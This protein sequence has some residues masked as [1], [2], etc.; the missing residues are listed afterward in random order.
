MVLEYALRSSFK[1]TPHLLGTFF[2]LNHIDQ[3]LPSFLFW[4]SF[5]LSAGPFWITVASSAKNTPITTLFRHFLI[6]QIFGWFPMILVISMMVKTI[7]QLHAGIY[8]SLYFVGA[9][10]IFYLAYKTLKSSLNKD[11]GF[12]FT[13]KAMMLLSWTNPKVWLTVPAGVITA[14]YTTSNI[15]DSLIF[16]F[17]GVP[18]YYFGFFMWANIGKYGAK[19]AKEKFNIFNTLL[20]VSYALYLLYEGI[21]ALNL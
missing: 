10:V 21:M 2:T 16:F 9:A 17:I 7:G 15:A 5:T 1:D 12:T 19:I 4:A 3:Y 20:L 6:Y 8:N 14:N 11:A 13:W 18:L